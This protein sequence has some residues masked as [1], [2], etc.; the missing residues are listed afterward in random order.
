MKCATTD[1]ANKYE[2]N[3]FRTLIFIWINRYAQSHFHA[4]RYLL[5][6]LGRFICGDFEIEEVH[7]KETPEYIIIIFF[8]YI[9]S[10][11]KYEIIY[12]RRTR[13]NIMKYKKKSFF[14]GHDLF[15]KMLTHPQ[16]FNQHTFEKKILSIHKDT[17]EEIRKPQIPI[18][19]VKA[20]LIYFIIIII[21]LFFVIYYL[22]PNLFQEI[23]LF[24]PCLKNNSS[25]FSAS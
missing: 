5:R 11:G 2:D 23:T 17:T 15:L 19:V 18:I 10:F 1:L 9:F 21:I 4:S 7:I 25:F 6:C 12:N 16:W 14:A 3:I 22:D 24:H 8:V 20:G 13:Y